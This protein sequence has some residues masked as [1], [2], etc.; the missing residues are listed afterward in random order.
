VTDVGT[1]S[2]VTREGRVL[3]CP[4]S[5]AA[6]GASLDFDAVRE[7]TRVLRAPEPDVGALLLVGEGPNFCTGADV[8]ALASTTD[9]TV[10][11]RALADELH[12]LV[13]ALVEAPLPVVA[14]VHGWAAG[15]G[16]SIALAADV[17]VA[18][19]STRLR[20]AYPGI[21]LTPDG[22]LTWT[23]PRAVGAAR[24]RHILLTDRVLCAD[25]AQELGLVAV[26]VADDAVAA[27]AQALAAR[28]AD[29]PTRA[30]GRTKQLLREGVHRDLDAQLDAE[31]ATIAESA[32]G[33][34]GAE[35]VAAFRERRPPRFGR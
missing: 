26:L 24:A 22:G 15:A 2:S 19:T 18:G 25:E 17:L 32:A 12:D 20:P 8:R 5:T 14:A 11:V 34:E 29:G 6:R 10:E 28:L 9:P 16:M 30:L 13:R 4:L 35:G 7:I 3:R 1:R 33:D 23:L 27:E 31:A 21:G